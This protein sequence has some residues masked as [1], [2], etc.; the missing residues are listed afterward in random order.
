MYRAVKVVRREDFEYEKTFEREFEGIQRY[1]QV[2]QDHPGLVDVLHVG[3]DDEE[4]FYY[5]VMEL[6]DDESGEQEVDDPGSYR[7]RTLTSEL[8]KRSATS[9]RESVEL[10]ISLAGALG[11]LH[12]AG[13]THRDVK[14]SNIIFVKGVPKLADVGL[15]ALSGQRTFVGTEGYVPPEGPGTS[16]ADLYS[17]AMVLYEMHT[18]KDRLDFPELP[19]NLE[20]PPTVNR[21]QWRKLNGVI[22]RAGS[23]D[24]RK[25]YETA[26]A[27][28]MALRGVLG[29]AAGE[30]KSRRPRPRGNGV[31]AAL[32]W[33][34][35]I[36]IFSVVG[37]G[38]YWLW[39]DNQAFFDKNANRFGE[40]GKEEG[41][42]GP[43]DSGEPPPAE[44]GVD[45]D[46]GKGSGFQ[47]VETSPGEAPLGE[48]VIRDEISK[49][50]KSGGKGKGEAGGG[51]TGESTEGGSSEN[52]EPGNGKSDPKEMV[53]NDP[54]EGEPGDDSGTGSKAGEKE[55]G[56]KPIVPE[57]VMGEL[58][59]TSRPDGATV[60]IEG[61]EVGRTATAPLELPVG[62]VEI[63]LKHPDYRD[64]RRRLDVKEGFQLVDVEL[65]PDL[66]P[67]P[68]NPWINS[69]GV[70]FHPAAAGGH[71]TVDP[72]SMQLFNVFLEET[73][74]QI[75][76]VGLKVKSQL[77]EL[78]GESILVAQVRDEKALWEFCDW[79]T[80][81]DRARGYLGDDRYH[82]PVRIPELSSGDSFYCEVAGEFGTLILNS[83]PEGAEVI[84]NGIPRG[85]TQLTLT[86]IRLGPYT[87][88]F[89]A[90][91]FEVA[92]EEGVLGTTGPVAEPVP[93]VVELQKDA[94]VEFG[95]TW[96]NSQ[97]MT[98][99]P[100]D[101][102]MVA[103]FETRV[104]DY[105]EYVTEAGN[106]VMPNAG[107]AQAL[108]HPVVG[109][110]RAEAAAFCAWLTERERAANLIRPWQTYRLPT[111]EEWS[112][113]AG[114]APVNGETPAARGRNGSDALPW[115]VEWP[116]PEQSGNFADLAAVPAFGRYVIDGYNDGFASTS[117]VGSFPATANGL[118]D[119]SGNAWEW[120]SDDFEP[121][122]AGLGVLRGGGWDSH[123]AA[124]LRVSYRNAMPADSRQ[125][126]FGFRYVLDGAGRR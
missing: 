25:R 33:L 16:S 40:G 88:E 42:G 82:R 68:G 65:I 77:E 43:P 95:R 23:P 4:G 22:C 72:V 45:P 113:I 34:V 125:A 52:G 102:F 38:G 63:V 79:M 97:G 117:P 17:L 75:P 120:V 7:P 73:G 6:A 44:P 114:E 10:G 41:K 19:T 100:V 98:L 62:T 37:V 85:E 89:R 2:S 11:H 35:T 96:V 5:Y 3:R 69:R 104:R 54:G 46:T 76:S 59:V 84:V 101:G 28:S 55:G 121:G 116:P 103:I 70:A 83:E 61:K 111:D 18:G 15:V 107:V 108:N 53:A 31:A 80:R 14:P 78:Q 91:G 24:P 39:K 21:D 92:V 57:V 71:V 106:A 105:R 8:R 86:D 29:E 32:A 109:V 66:G 115:G 50:G 36:T 123:E 87:V 110:T 112:R 74:R 26:H 47:L 126:H 48:V 51:E 90:P 124:V 13:L 27:F 64:T 99:L 119:L 12:Q 94:S 58:K 81:A 56:T 93:L 118:H 60:W 122:S 9:V 49:G 67:L 1:E 30:G 20:I